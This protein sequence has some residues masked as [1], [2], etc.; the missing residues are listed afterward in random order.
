LG[1][2]EKLVL[3]RISGLKREETIKDEEKHVMEDMR[4]VYILVRKL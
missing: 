4:H 1:A 2:F 3:R